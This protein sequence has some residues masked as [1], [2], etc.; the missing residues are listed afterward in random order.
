MKILSLHIENFGKLSGY[1]HV[2][3]SGLNVIENKNAW[4][5]TTLA[6][7]IKAMFYGMDKKGN[8]KAYDAERSKYQP[9][10]GGTYGGSL[11]FEVDGKA[12]RVL[13]T[14][15]PT[16]EGDRFELL[17]LQTNKISKDFSSN[18][19]EELFDVGKNTFCISTFFAQGDIDSE[20]NDEVRSH[21][22]GAGSF[23]GD[24]ERYS[25]AV[26]KLKE[27]SRALTVATP[28]VHEIYGAQQQM[29]EKKAELEQLEMQKQSLSKQIASLEETAREMP[30]PQKPQSDGSQEKLAQLNSLKAQ[31]A[32]AEKRLAIKQKQNSS[33][34]TKLWVMFGFGIVCAVLALVF[35]VT[36][37]ASYLTATIGAVAGVLLI[38]WAI[39]FAKL[40]K[41][42]GEETSKLKDDLENITVQ[43]SH[44]EQQIILI[45][46]SA[47]KNINALSQ[48]AQ[49]DKDLAVAKIRLSQIE[50][51]IEMLVEDIEEQ[52]AAIASMQ[53]AKQENSQKQEIIKSALEFL[54][55]AKNNISTRFV[56][57]M[58]QKFDD[59]LR[60]LEEK[61]QIKLDSDLNVL[62]DTQTGVREDKYLSRGKRDLVTICKRFALIESVFQKQKPF[63]ILDDPF[64]NLDENSLKNMLSLV[65]QFAKQYQVIYLIC[66]HSRAK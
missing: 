56:E 58:Q 62:L 52:D 39:L 30:E 40:K 64:V 65:E 66:H 41:E 24:A 18:L 10:Q 14:F 44:I 50:R 8:S 51:Q 15:A 17:D 3:N 20:I 25:Q 45:A 34:K 53:I 33:S 63:V 7:F 59:F 22:S 43:I 38:L 48:Q 13:R 60:K 47:E 36:G 4:G 32:E 28:K 5:K 21:L 27:F 35:G 9:W 2:F 12:Y 11:I 49:Q 19:G 57:P 29:D 23:S 1:D 61:G 37:Q 6:V 26:K 46:A 42:G 16:P 31:R 55:Q 54:E